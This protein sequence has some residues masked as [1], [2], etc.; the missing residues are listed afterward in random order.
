[1]AFQRFSLGHRFLI[2]SRPE[3]NVGKRRLTM[4]KFHILLRPINFFWHV[5]FIAKIL[6][7][8]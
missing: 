8:S 1:M 6:L 7:I 3:L 4:I 2:K 5:F